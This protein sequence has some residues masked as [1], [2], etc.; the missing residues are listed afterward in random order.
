MGWIVALLGLAAAVAGGGAVAMGWPVVQLERGWTMVIAGAALAS[1]G[2]VCLGLAVQI[3]EMRRL[4]AALERALSRLA[5]EAG[6][7][8]ETAATFTAPRRDPMSEVTA[9]PPRPLPQ[10]RA[11]EARPPM[12]EQAAPPEEPQ[13]ARSF[14][15][16]DTTFVVFADGSIEAR[17]AQGTRRFGSMEEVRAYLETSVS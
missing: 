12:R 10:P 8:A 16:G 3:F 7:E 5:A 2:L 1:G 17:T 9:V 15:V 6:P 13:P 4:R 11:A 14:T